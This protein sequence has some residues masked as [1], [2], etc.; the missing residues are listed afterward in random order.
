MALTA[1]YCSIAVRATQP[2]Q[3]GGVK[4]AGVPSAGWAEQSGQRWAGL[5]TSPLLEGQDDLS[6]CALQE[7]MR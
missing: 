4:S 5:G 2:G 1:L 6:P 7:G 3:E